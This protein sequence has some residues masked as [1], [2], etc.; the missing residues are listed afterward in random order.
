MRSNHRRR[1]VLVSSVAVFELWY[2]VA[3]SAKQEFNH[4]GL[5]T[6]RQANSRSPIRMSMRTAGSVELSSK[7][8]VSQ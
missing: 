7:P 8:P 3:K 6:F 5:E 2:G 4:K 1:H